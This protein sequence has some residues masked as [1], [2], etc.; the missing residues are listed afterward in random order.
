MTTFSFLVDFICRNFNF[1]QEELAEYWDISADLLKQWKNKRGYPQKK[2]K[3]SVEEIV[4]IFA[5]PQNASLA[6]QDTAENIII[7][8]IS[9]IKS[10][11]YTDENL[12]D[13]MTVQEFI[14]FMK[15]F[16]RQ[17]G[18]ICFSRAT[19]K[20]NQR[21]S[22]SEKT[23]TNFE[24]IIAEIKEKGLPIIEKSGYINRR[25]AILK[26]DG[27]EGDP[28]SETDILKHL[29][30]VTCIIAEGGQGKTTLVQNL[31]LALG[32]F[33]HCAAALPLS[34]VIDYGAN[35]RESIPENKRHAL[36]FLI[37]DGFDEIVTSKD[38]K[39]LLTSL[40]AFEDYAT[41]QILITTRSYEDT[42]LIKEKTDNNATVLTLLP[43]SDDDCVTLSNQLLGSRAEA[44]LELIG[45][46]QSQNNTIIDSTP[47]PAKKISNN[48]FYLN[49][50]ISIFE[51]TGTIPKTQVDILHEIIKAAISREEDLASWTN[52]PVHDYI[53][54]SEQFESILEIFAVEK[55]KQPEK[56]DLSIFLKF[57]T[58]EKVNN[59]SLYARHISAYLQARGLLVDGA[60]SHQLLLEYL[61]AK[62]YWNKIDAQDY[63]DESVRDLFAHYK[64]PRWHTV[65][66][67]F[68][69]IAEEK[70][71]TDR[72]K[73]LYTAIIDTGLIVD[74][75]L[76]L[77][78]FFANENWYPCIPKLKLIIKDILAKS[79][80]GQY[81]AYGPLFYYIPEYKL[82]SLLIEVLKDFEGD[83]KALALVRDVCFIFG[84]YNTVSEIDLRFE[85]DGIELYAA[86]GGQLAGVRNALCE[87][88]YTGNTDSECGSDIYPRC[89]NVAESIAIA[90]NGA[91]LFTRFHT[92]FEDELGLYQ[93]NMVNVLN[94]EPIGFVS[95]PYNAD[96]TERLL[97]KAFSWPYPGHIERFAYLD[98]GK[99]RG[100]AFTPAKHSGYLINEYGTRLRPVSSCD[101]WLKKQI[102]VLYVPENI[103]P[104]FELADEC[105]LRDSY[106]KCRAIYV[107]KNGIAYSNRFGH[108]ALPCG[109]TSLSHHYDWSQIQSIIIPNSVTRIEA[110]AFS[111]CNQLHTIQFPTCMEYLGPMALRG[112][113]V[114]SVVLP[115]E[116]QVIDEYTFKDCHLLTDISFPK[117]LSAIKRGACS[118]CI[119]LR[120]VDLSD[121]KGLHSIDR[122][123]FTSC[124]ALNSV[125]L[126]KN[127]INIGP[128]A[129]A[130]CTALTEIVIPKTVTTIGK[131][132]FYDCNLKS[133]QISQTFKDQIEDIFGN[134]DPEAVR[135]ID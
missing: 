30:K 18:S 101:Y 130:C 81:P 50:L 76:M 72:R 90:Q 26:A 40:K 135:F 58:T 39:K 91:G 85:K 32:E 125:V 96:L 52:S 64:D 92:P 48:P 80:N 113:G 34:N 44:F 71:T 24:S 46:S 22:N 132:A 53:G 86:S 21:D 13:K 11:G 23:K 73:L 88:F 66:E 47:K 62:A 37:L 45:Q 20:A 29:G 57:F 14:G 16:L 41:M 122:A 120:A 63:S 93:H 28:F 43:F 111:R 25:L 128:M 38:K 35:F 9:D 49:K 87:L 119:N 56:E 2:A 70:S 121:C 99:I 124:F 129:F 7:R 67:L 15:I 114:R 31:H 110:L 82:Y 108:I 68:L 3:I 78:F 100:V 27:T 4:E 134:V 55:Y 1:S 6:V 115:G 59:P 61:T 51:Q 123:A 10:Q 102:S 77:D 112:T 65:F 60:F 42:M 74:Y 109:I 75:S 84:G 126:P 95:L 12:P 36:K 107:E 83:V 94:G 118:F 33:C 103:N 17:D 19:N 97:M 79:I 117:T 54:E 131:G 89:F 8:F 69:S 5:N 133:I 105:R 116:L 104:E 98:G 127:L 106:K